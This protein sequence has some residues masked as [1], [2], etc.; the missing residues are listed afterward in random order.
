MNL[1]AAIIGDMW[2]D[3]LVNAISARALQRHSRAVILEFILVICAR[4][5]RQLELD[6]TFLRLVSDHVWICD[7]LCVCTEI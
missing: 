4:Q 1:S 7:G 5:A 6:D 2:W 3:D